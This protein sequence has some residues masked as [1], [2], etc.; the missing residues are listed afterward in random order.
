MLL[1]IHT[2]V[3]SSKRQKSV[4]VYDVGTRVGRSVDNWSAFWF[5]DPQGVDKSCIQEYDCSYDTLK[6]LFRLLESCKSHF[7]ASV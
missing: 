3:L 5:M 4:Q 2:K 1:R 7:M 6:F